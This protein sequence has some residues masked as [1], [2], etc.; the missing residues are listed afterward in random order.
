MPMLE[1]TV[2]AVEQLEKV[3]LVIKRRVGAQRPG[4]SAVAVRLVQRA[5]A[6]DDGV[7]GSE[8]LSLG[9]GSDRRQMKRMKYLSSLVTPQMRRAVS[10]RRRTVVTAG[11]T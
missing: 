9:A 5:R 8:G 10:H 4:A 6:Q 3:H 2:H 1:D 7:D 11:S